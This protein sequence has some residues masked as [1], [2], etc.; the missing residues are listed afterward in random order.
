MSEPRVFIIHRTTVPGAGGVRTDRHDLRPAQQFGR[1]VNIFKDEDVRQDSDAIVRKLARI[2]EDFSDEDAILC[3]GDPLI[4]MIAG[5]VLQS[6]CEN[7]SQMRIL[8][9]DK[10]RR[11]YQPYYIYRIIPA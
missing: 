9:W 1:L 6:H 10:I 8:K 5:M 3:T 2:L 4:L 11:D 7:W